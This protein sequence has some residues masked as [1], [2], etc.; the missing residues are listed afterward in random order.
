MKKIAMA[1]S[2]VALACAGPALADGRGGDSFSRGSPGS[3]G[4]G[5]PFGHVIRGLWGPALFGPPGFH[6]P[7]NHFGWFFGRHW[8]W[9]RPHHPHWP[10][11]PPHSP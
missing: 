2:L 7:G 4:S 1:A 10:H 11:H 8:G 5:G 3:F 6:S 9:Y